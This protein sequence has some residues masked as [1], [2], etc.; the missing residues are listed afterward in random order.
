LV[1]GVLAG[2]FTKNIP[3]EHV[4]E[5]PVFRRSADSYFLQVVDCV[6]YALLKREVPPTPTVRR[7]G[8]NKMFEATL[9]GMCFKPASPKDP[10]GIV[11]K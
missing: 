4:I 5:D 3:T 11:R 7:Y 8:I 6:A 10:L 9:A 2:G 1:A